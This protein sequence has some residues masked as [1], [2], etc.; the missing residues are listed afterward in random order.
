MGA[1]MSALAVLV[2]VWT[3]LYTFALPSEI[4][5]RRRSE[6]ESDVWESEHDPDVPHHALVLRL[7]RGMPAD[8]LWRLEVTPS[9]QHAPRAR[10]APPAVDADL[11]IKME[12]GPVR[13]VAGRDLA[14]SRTCLCRLRLPR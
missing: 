9:R 1:R 3:Y 10:A 11:N 6:I 5:D 2:R 8:V 13:E 12:V 14:P 7:L 4:R